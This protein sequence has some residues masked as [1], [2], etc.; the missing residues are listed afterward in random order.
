MRDVIG[1]SS[2]MASSASDA[3]FLVGEKGATYLSRAM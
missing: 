1:F 2:Y 3:L